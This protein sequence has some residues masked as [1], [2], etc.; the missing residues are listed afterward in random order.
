MN[1]LFH[2]V[3]ENIKGK[4]LYPLNRL[5]NIY[6]QAYKKHVKKYKNREYLLN[7]KI[8]YLNCLWND[9]LHLTA[10]DPIKLKETLEE[11]GFK[12]P[13]RKWYKINPKLLTKKDSIVF[14]FEKAS[15]LQPTKEE[16]KSFKISKLNQYGQI[17]EKTMR[18]YKYCLRNNQRPLLFH[19]VPH[20]LYRGIIPTKNLEVII[21]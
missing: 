19:Y 16:Y 5:K 2:R 20:I 3:P 17:G 13:K 1:Y 15:K 21:A 9:V 14:L 11:L 18:Y 7:E 4:I 10:V 8:P 12:P 6:P